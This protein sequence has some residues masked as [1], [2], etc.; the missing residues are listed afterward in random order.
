MFYPQKVSVFLI[1]RFGLFPYKN[2]DIRKLAI[3]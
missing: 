1:D 3:R 2:A